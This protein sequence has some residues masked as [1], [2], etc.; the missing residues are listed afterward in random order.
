VKRGVAIL[1]LEIDVGFLF[2]ALHES[3]IPAV[4]GCQVQNVLAFRIGYS[5]IEPL[6]FQKLC[7]FWFILKIGIGQGVALQR[8]VIIEDEVAPK[9]YSFDKASYC[10]FVAF[11]WVILEVLIMK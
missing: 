5:Q 11:A 2:Y 10:F 9:R 4:D 3:Q 8:V 1:V 6:V 7:D